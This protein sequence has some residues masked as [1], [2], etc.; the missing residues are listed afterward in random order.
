M[1][2]EDMRLLWRAELATLEV[3]IGGLKDAVMRLHMG[4]ADEH[5]V[6]LYEGVARQKQGRA[7]WLRERLQVH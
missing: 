7:E 4:C 3:E 6:N 5:T 1:S 2:V